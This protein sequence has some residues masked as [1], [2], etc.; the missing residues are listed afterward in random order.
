MS[1]NFSLKKLEKLM[2][3]KYGFV[4]PR[5]CVHRSQPT[6][7]PD[8]LCSLKDWWDQGVLGVLQILIHEME[9]G[10]GKVKRPKLRLSVL[11]RF[12]YNFGVP[13]EWCSHKY[14]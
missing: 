12:W 3:S 4:P 14:F 5:V 13:C 11:H 6:R 7:I 10:D 1:L 2:D 8:A 9:L